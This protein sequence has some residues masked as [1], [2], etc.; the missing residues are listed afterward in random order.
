MKNNRTP[1]VLSLMLLVL[2]T[3]ACSQKGFT[4]ADW[5]GTT[6]QDD[7]LYASNNTNIYAINTNGQEVNRYPAEA[8]RGATFFAAPAFA[9]EDQL[10]VGSYSNDFYSFNPN[11]GSVNWVFENNNRFIADALVMENMI[12]AP[13]ADGQVYALDASNQGQ[14]VW[15]FSPN[16]K[17][18]DNK[19]I[20]A[21]PVTDGETLFVASMDSML[22][23]I[24]LTNGKLRWQTDLD[25]AM[26]DGPALGQDGTLYVGTFA[27]E[28]IA[29]DKQNGSVKWRSQTQQ[30]V[31]GC[32]SIDETTLYVTDLSGTLYAYDTNNGKQLWQVTGNGAATGAPLVHEGNIYFVTENGE[33]YALN[34]EGVIRWTRSVEEAALYGSPVLFGD[35]IVVKSAETNTLLYAYDVNGQSQW[36]F[37]PKN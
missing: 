31:W 37:T 24:N 21:S 12:Y 2:L 32:P 7:I 22:Y 8:I 35:L 11:N 15:I 27:A 1:I 26:V 13:N 6:I 16:E 18:G 25:A 10:L 3:S 5:P 4:P 19:P 29:V 36:Q 9:G 20:W 17:L 33:L 34:Q 23:A 28:V 14:I 30:W